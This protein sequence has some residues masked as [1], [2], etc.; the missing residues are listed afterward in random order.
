MLRYG[1]V[2]GP[3]QWGTV[4]LAAGVIGQGGAWRVTVVR[5]LRIVIRSG[6]PALFRR[7]LSFVSLA[8]TLLFYSSTLLL[9]YFCS[10]SALLLLYF[11]S[12]SHSR[13]YVPL[14][15]SC[16][17]SIASVLLYLSLLFYILYLFYFIYT[18]SILLLPLLSRD[19]INQ[20]IT[21]ATPIQLVGHCL[22]ACSGYLL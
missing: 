21:P 10:T 11:Y 22:G 6:S 8:S 15:Y 9:L 13:S 16:C 1:T 14:T 12:T 5:A 3:S 2:L 20:P 17:R 18:T 7:L 19:L 4:T